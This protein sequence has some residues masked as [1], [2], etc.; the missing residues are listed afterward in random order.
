[1]IPKDEVYTLMKLAFLSL[2]VLGSLLLLMLWGYAKATSK[3]S[4]MLHPIGHVKKEGQRT[5]LIINKAYQ[6][7]LLGLE[8]FSHI[9]VYFWFDKNDNPSKRATLRVHPMGNPKNPL[10]GVFAT[11]SPARPNLIGMTLSRI[12][13]VKGNTVEIDWTDA[14]ENTLILDIKPFIHAIDCAEPSR[15]PAWLKKN[16]WIKGPQRDPS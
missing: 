5:W 11:R 1:M 8:G 4:F 13:G 2:G 10:T 9:Y 14:L 6:D 7:G 16:D 3:D 15:V 12:I